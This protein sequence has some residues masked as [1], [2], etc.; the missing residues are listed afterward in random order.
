MNRE[1]ATKALG[2]Y[3]T[4]VTQTKKQEEFFQHAKQNLERVDIPKFKVVYC[5]FN[6]APCVTRERVG[7]LF[8][9]SRI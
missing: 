6:L 5:L 8:K 3:K 4:F 1:Q 9:F 7:R 2:L